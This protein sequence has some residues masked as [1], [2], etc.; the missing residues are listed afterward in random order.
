MVMSEKEFLRAYPT[1]SHL[2]E[3]KRGVATKGI[4]Q[5]VV[6]FSNTEGGVVLIGV[7]DD[8]TVSG[9]EMTQGTIDDLHQIMRDVINPGRYEIGQV[10][11][12][13][14]PVTILAVAKRI[15]GFAQTPNGRVIVCKGTRK[16][17]LFGSDLQNFINAR[18]GQRFEETVTDYTLDSASKD[19]LK[20]LAKAFGWTDAN[21]L[22]ERLKERHLLSDSDHL[23]VAGALYLVDKPREKLGKAYVEIFRYR[24]DE[25]TYDRRVEIDGPLDQQLEH[26]VE[27]VAQELGNEL[28]VLGVKRYELPR[29]PREVLREALAN[30]LAHRSYEATGTAVRIDLRDDNVT[31]TSPGGLPEPVTVENI[32]ETQAARNHEVITILRRLGLAEDAGRG[33]DIMIDRMQQE[34]LD[35]PKFIDNG[36]S[37]EVVLPIRSPVTPEERAWIREVEAR[38]L[39]EPTD[40]IVL[41]HAARG[42]ELTNAKVRELLN[43]DHLKARETLRRLKDQSFLEQ[44]G[45]RGGA[46]YVLKDTLA[47]PAGLRLKDD[48]LDALVIELAQEGPISNAKIRV[49]TGLDRIEALKVL[50]RLLNAGH[51]VRV[52]QRRGTR[53]RLPDSSIQTSPKT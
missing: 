14:R 13:D 8:G 31:V 17:A 2:A 16:E 6:G 15:E 12:D 28:V 1:E 39:T 5:A 47:P 24:D 35:P 18:T 45:Q 22:P 21:S 19:L 7:E 42:E 49:R 3:R 29:I 25:S 30:A 38:G 43:V 50:E 53:Y 46:A 23:T 44:R 40:R 10:F 41:V 48:E 4:Q 51:L 52:G 9:R 26:S 20:R 33:I 11:V 34:L 27:F 36:K 32:R 37:V